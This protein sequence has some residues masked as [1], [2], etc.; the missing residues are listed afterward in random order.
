MTTRKEVL[1]NKLKN[2]KK[3]S[4]AVMLAGILTAIIGYLDYR[5]ADKALM[6]LDEGKLDQMMLK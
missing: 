5:D 4:I 1:I 6:I 3:R 2:I